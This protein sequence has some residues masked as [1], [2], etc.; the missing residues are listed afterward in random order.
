MI[1]CS[2]PSVRENPS[3]D[4]MF[5]SCN[6]SEDSEE[7]IVVCDYDVLVAV[8]TFGTSIPCDTRYLEG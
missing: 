5:W 3:K 2:Y 6:S 4:R 1:S 7:E 8:T